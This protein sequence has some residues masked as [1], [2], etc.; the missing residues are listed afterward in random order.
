MC[1]KCGG[2]CV[3]SGVATWGFFALLLNLLNVGGALLN[4]LWLT[5][6]LFVAFATCPVL[7]KKLAEGC[8]CGVCSP[9]AE[10][11]KLKKGKKK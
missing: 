8:T 7:N 3:I 5:I 10:K 6:L 4:A 11:L 9:K 1:G 2:F